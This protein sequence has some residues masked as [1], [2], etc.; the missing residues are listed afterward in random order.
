VE[1]S[2][3]CGGVNGNGRLAQAPARSGRSS[4]IRRNH[5]GCG[6]PTNLAAVLVAQWRRWLDRGCRERGPAELRW[7]RWRRGRRR[8]RWEWRGWRSASTLGISAARRR[9]TFG[10]KSCADCTVVAFERDLLWAG[11]VLAV[12]PAREMVAHVAHPL[13]T[14]AHSR[15][16]HEDPKRIHVPRKTASRHRGRA[17][18]SSSG[19]VV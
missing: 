13:S 6:C 10:S 5:D 1:T 14:A 2:H 16:A 17:R 3:P 18:L 19:P 8:R 12:R 9:D 11:E 7:Q 15:P 4:R